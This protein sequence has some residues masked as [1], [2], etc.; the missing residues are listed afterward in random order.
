[1]IIAMEWRSL[2]GA[3]LAFVSSESPG[4]FSKKKIYVRSLDQWKA[5]PLHEVGF[6]LQPFFS[7]DGQWLGYWLGAED[8]SGNKLKKFPLGGAVST[9]IC[10]CSFP[11]SL[12]TRSISGTG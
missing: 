3:R 7:P 6:M 1:M 10:D 2:K 12:V 9:T 11:F 8:G 4:V 5:T